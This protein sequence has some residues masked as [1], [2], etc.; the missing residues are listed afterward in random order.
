[1]K[2]AVWKPPAASS[3]EASRERAQRMEKS[4]ASIISALDAQGRWTEDGRMYT[5]RYCFKN[6]ME[7]EGPVLKNGWIRTGTFIQ[8]MGRLA[9]YVRLSR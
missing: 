2:T 8:N 1:M 6:D 9:E 7:Y 5:K 3:S 4:I